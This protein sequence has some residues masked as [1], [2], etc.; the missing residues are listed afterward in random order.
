MFNSPYKIILFL[1][2]FIYATPQFAQIKKENK[3]LIGRLALSDDDYETALENFNA[4]IKKD[5]NN[6]EPFYLRGVTKLELSDYI[7]AEKDFSRAIYLKPRN[8]DTY[9]VR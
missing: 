7:G 2:L 4:V 8:V 9:I 3:L 1:L 5:S 6:Y